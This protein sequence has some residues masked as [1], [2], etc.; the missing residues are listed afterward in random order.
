MTRRIHVIGIGAGSPEHVTAEA[1]AALAEVDV[2]LVADK[3]ETKDELIAFHLS[4]LYFDKGVVGVSDA[5][6]ILFNERLAD[7]SLSELAELV[8]ALPPWG[9][10]E[11]LR[12]CK[13]AS[14]IQRARDQLLAKGAQ[15][16]GLSE[17]RVR[18]ASE[19]KV[20]CLAR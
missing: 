13:N 16:G 12:L 7:L 3:G 18:K 8:L 14:L 11:D 19:V 5:A 9:Q 17:D 20:A 15:D 4:A 10:Y 2:F 6:R 1:A